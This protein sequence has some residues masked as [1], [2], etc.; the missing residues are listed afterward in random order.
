MLLALMTITVV[1][2]QSAGIG[3]TAEGLGTA[4]ITIR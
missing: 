3:V 4:R 1:D 2:G